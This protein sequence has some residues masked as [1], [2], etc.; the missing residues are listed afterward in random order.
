MCSVNVAEFR[1]NLSHYI[2]LSAVE[3]VLITKNGETVAVLSNPDKKYY[4]TLVKLCG[5]LKE[6]DSNEN[7][8]DMIGEEIMKRCGF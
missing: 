5:C 3:D 1:N 4:E 8:K 7:Y 6:L 2:G